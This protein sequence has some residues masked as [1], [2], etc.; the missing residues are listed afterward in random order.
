MFK[1][2]ESLELKKSLVQLKEGAISLSAMLNKVGKGELYFGINDEGKIVGLD[3][4]KKTLADITHEIQ[5]NLKPLPIKVL[6][7]EVILEEKSVLELM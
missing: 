3:V 5:N 4:G 7:E 1:E 2:S 6:I